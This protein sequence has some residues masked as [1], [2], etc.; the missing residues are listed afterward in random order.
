MA[1]RKYIT[2]EEFDNSKIFDEYQCLYKK[3]IE[4]KGCEYD[5]MVEYGNDF[6][7]C[8]FIDSKQI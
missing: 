4:L 6:L 5:S 8:K 2:I 1:H 7:I 3:D